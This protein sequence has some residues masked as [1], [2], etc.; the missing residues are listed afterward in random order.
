MAWKD[1]VEAAHTRNTMTT[2]RRRSSPRR[3]RMEW[4]DEE[5]LYTPLTVTIIVFNGL[6]LLSIVLGFRALWANPNPQVWDPAGHNHEI[7]DTIASPPPNRM[8]ASRRW[9][10]IKREDTQSTIPIQAFQVDVPLLGQ[11]GMVVG[12]GT[13]DGFSGIDTTVKDNSTACQVTLA[14]HTFAS[15]YGSPFV[16]NYTPPD[17]MGDSNTAVMNLTV[18]SQGRQYDRLFIL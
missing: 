16:G 18:Q 15:S 14:V 2:P 7:R 8:H 4:S 11:G 10:A 13:P 5:R 17:C 6:F 3:Q 1:V 9:A 12:A